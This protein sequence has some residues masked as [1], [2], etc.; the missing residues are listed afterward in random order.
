MAKVFEV[1]GSRELGTVTHEGEIYDVAFSPGGD[2]LATVGGDLSLGGEVRLTT[3]PGLG[4][5]ARIAHDM[6]VWD[7][8]FSPDGSFLASAGGDI[9][10]KAGLKSNR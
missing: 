7:V 5:V 9:S 1:E 3:V 8:A 4:E 10:R 6:P 2:M